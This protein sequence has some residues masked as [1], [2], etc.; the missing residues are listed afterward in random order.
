MRTFRSV[1]SI[2]LVAS[3][4]LPTF[5]FSF[6]E[7]KAAPADIDKIR[8]EGMNRSHA[9]ATMKYLSD[10][11]GARL[12]NSPSQ[13]RAN[14]WTKEQ[15]EKWGMKNAIVD[16]WGEFGKGWELK[17]FNAT[18]MVGDEFIAFRSYP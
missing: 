10:V 17:R 7:T 6:T 11:I 14:K 13:R 5:A 9:M 18:A 1:M 12:T 8:D 3:L 16:P 15:L 4:S 2:A